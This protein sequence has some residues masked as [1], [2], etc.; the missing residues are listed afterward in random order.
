MELADVNV[1][2]VIF[3]VYGTLL[4]IGPPPVDADARWQQLFQ[5][6]LHAPPLLSRLDFYVA[7]NKL[8][9]KRHEASRARG[10]AWP[11]VQWPAV[12]AEVLPPLRRLPRAKLDEFLYRQIQIGHTPLLSDA[13]VAALRKLKASGCLFGIA[14]NAQA[15]TLREL[16]EALVRHGLGMDLFERDLCFWSFEHGF[17]KPDPHV[18]QILSTRLEARGI[19]RAEALMVGDRLDNDCEPARAFGWQTWLLKPKGDSRIPR[20]GN[21]QDL[22]HQLAIK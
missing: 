13:T 22:L 16:E 7:S 20:S 5:E 14:S 15:Y 8:V 4:E 9:A 2:A 17:S 12:V 6:M 19:S 21:W 11:E 18:F 3:D 1:R 10:I